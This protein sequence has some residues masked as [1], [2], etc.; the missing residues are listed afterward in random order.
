[1][2]QELEKLRVKLR[3]VDFVRTGSGGGLEQR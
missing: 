2:Q 3:T 1:M